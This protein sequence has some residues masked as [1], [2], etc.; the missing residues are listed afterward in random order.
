MT[1]TGVQVNRLT[2]LVA[3]GA[4]L[5]TAY[6]ALDA[7]SKQYDEDKRKA[8]E[9]FTLEVHQI[10]DQFLGKVFDVIRGTDRRLE[11]LDYDDTGID[12]DPF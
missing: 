3:R 10:N 1:D 8:H 5:N 2:L 4:E 12:E 7:L 6:E 11:V 9:R